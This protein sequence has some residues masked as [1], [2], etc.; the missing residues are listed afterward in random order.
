M[1]S[2]AS[3]IAVVALVAAVTVALV[4]V[5]CAVVWYVTCGMRSQLLGPSVWRGRSDT[6][7]VAL[8]F[9]DGPSADT[10]Q[11]LDILERHDLKATFFML[12]RQV[13]SLPETA[14]R[15]AAEGH[16]VGNHSYSHPSFL[17]SGARETR[18]QIE[19]AQQIIAEVVG[20]PPRIARPPYGARTPSYFDAARRLGLRTV[21]W[22]VSGF[23]WNQKD[24][25]KIARRVLGRATPGS[26]I[27]L[28]D[29]DS[30]LKANRGATVKAVQLIIEGLQAR[31]IKIV[32][33]SQLLQ[34]EQ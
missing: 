32:P 14:R 33:L 22:S 2:P 5:G 7:A 6:S 25:T 24:P 34:H 3:T 13:E 27:V 4:F 20:S 12:G 28:H 26:I 29:A 10:E 15:V 18:Q 21:L 1:F 17:F 30:D 11:I 8:T 16:E 9:D 31:G 19:R 23:D